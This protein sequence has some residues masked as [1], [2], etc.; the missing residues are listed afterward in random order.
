MSPRTAAMLFLALCCVLAGCSS[1][2]PTATP[3]TTPDETP[4][5][6]PETT[7]DPPN[8]SI[9][10]YRSLSETQQ[11]AFDRALTTEKVGFGPE[12][13]SLDYDFRTDTADVFVEHEY[14]KRNG[15]Y[16]R[17]HMVDYFVAGYAFSTKKTTDVDE[18]TV[19]PFENV[20]G[21]GVE[22]LRQALE[23]GGY[24]FPYGTERNNISLSIRSGSV[25][26]YRGTNYDFA[27]A[28]ADH[29]AYEMRA[30]ERD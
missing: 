24:S 19:T 6:T 22:Y 1:G 7:P 30:I 14:V 13:P 18:E 16:Y 5:A 27:I 28:V 11:Q 29:P 17:T 12:S 9:V 3:E 8:G 4:V 20:T 15:T 2:G 26:E 25:V 10:A 21:P 23:E